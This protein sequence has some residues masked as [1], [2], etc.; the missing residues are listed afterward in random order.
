ML[1]SALQ[2]IPAH[3]G[4]ALRRNSNRSQTIGVPCASC[5]AQAAGVSL[6]MVHD[7][8]TRSAVQ[9]CFSA[10]HRLTHLPKG[11]AKGLVA[12]FSD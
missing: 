10:R 11:L 2:L 4:H 8:G 5:S 12:C 9:L 3:G 1:R 7:H 6:T